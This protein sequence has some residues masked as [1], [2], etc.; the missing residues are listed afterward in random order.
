[1]LLASRARAA[2]TNFGDTSKDKFAAINVMV[3]SLSVMR[4]VAA[5][6]TLKHDHR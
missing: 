5:S 6:N 2:Q 3:A 4:P 1:M